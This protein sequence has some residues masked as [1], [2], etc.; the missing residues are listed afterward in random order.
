MTRRGRRTA[1]AV[2]FLERPV[3]GV[4]EVGIAALPLH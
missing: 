1:E 3:V 2:A 4:T